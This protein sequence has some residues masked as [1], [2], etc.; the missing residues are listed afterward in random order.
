MSDDPYCYPGSNLLRNLLGLH[1]RSE[2]ERAERQLI[3]LRIEEGT[4]SG[5]FDLNH[6]QAIHRHLFQ[7]I[8]DWAGEIR[9]VEISKDGSQFQFRQF[10]S[11]WKNPA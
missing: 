11:K 3:Q 6:L 1:D 2:L 9:Q 5:N 8:Y 7:D 10:I 4:P